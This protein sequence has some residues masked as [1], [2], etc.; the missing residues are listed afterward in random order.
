MFIK[1]I[2]HLGILTWVSW[3]V[4]FTYSLNKFHLMVVY[5]HAFCLGS[6]YNSMIPILEWDHILCGSI[7]YCSFA[8]TPP[9]GFGNLDHFYIQH[10]SVKFLPSC[11]CYQSSFCFLMHNVVSYDVGTGQPL[12]PM[13]LDLVDL[14]YWIL[15]FIFIW[16]CLFSNRTTFVSYDVGF[17]ILDDLGY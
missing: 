15:W 10:Q 9:C 16:I 8:I 2:S 7:C 5:L 14:G 13:M 17:G 11:N 12:C 3:L 6:L 4:K 1:F